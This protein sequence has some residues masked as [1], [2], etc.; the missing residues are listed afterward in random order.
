MCYSIRYDIEEYLVKIQKSDKQE[1]TYPSKKIIA[2][3]A[4]GVA[5]STTSCTST[6]KPKPQVTTHKRIYQPGS[7]AGGAPVA[8]ARPRNK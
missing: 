1:T 5:L 8:V 4:L 3:L 2:S 7:I 6:A